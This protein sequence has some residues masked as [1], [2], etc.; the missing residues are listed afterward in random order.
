M[1]TV[2]LTKSFIDLMKD[3]SVNIGLA[4]IFILIVIVILSVLPAI[5]AIRRNID[6]KK[7]TIIGN[8][9][10]IALLFVNYLVP[11]ALW[12]VLMI[13]S[14]KGKKNEPKQENN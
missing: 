9:C 4:A 11:I 7:F 8:V 5:I 13:I 12:V 6:L 14:I 2:L 1:E 10:M 3:L